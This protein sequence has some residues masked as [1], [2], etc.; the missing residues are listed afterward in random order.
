MADNCSEDLIQPPPR[1]A[2]VRTDILEMDIYA[3]PQERR[4]ALSVRCWHYFTKYMVEFILLCIVTFGV[5]VA[6]GVICRYASLWICLKRNSDY[7]Y[8][9]T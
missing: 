3:P 2:R 7:A 6:Y 1:R 8:D 5:L 4:K 9:P